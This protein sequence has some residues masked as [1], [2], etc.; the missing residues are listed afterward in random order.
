MVFEIKHVLSL[1]LFFQEPLPHPVSHPPVGHRP[2]PDQGEGVQ[3]VW[4]DK[5]VSPPGGGGGVLNGKGKN[6]HMNNN[7]FT[8][9]TE[10]VASNVTKTL[11]SRRV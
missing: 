8:R 5:G 11:E 10:S 4:L 3:E 9:K 6:R 7:A 2:Q 1:S